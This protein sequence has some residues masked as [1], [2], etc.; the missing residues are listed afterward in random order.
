[1]YSQLKCCPAPVLDTDYL[2]QLPHCDC[3]T[4]CRPPS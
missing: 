3:C 4:M 1:M 2:K